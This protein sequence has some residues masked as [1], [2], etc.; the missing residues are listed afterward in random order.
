MVNRVWSECMD[1][2]NIF[3]APLNNYLL[4]IGHCTNDNS[5]FQKYE[6]YPTLIV[7][8][9]HTTYSDDCFLEFIPVC[10]WIVKVNFRW[11]D[12]NPGP[13]DMKS[14]A[15]PTPW[16]ICTKEVFVC[17][18]IIKCLFVWK[19]IIRQLWKLPNR[20]I[21]LYSGHHTAVNI[22]QLRLYL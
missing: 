6:I 15:Q 4:I 22:S 3:S 14:D 7:Q 16:S 18:W 9:V 21:A 8:K 11:E 2:Q 10:A 1:V 12:S 19:Q 5:G 13:V 17:C 20:R